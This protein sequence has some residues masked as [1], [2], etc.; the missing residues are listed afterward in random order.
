MLYVLSY[1]AGEKL[2]THNDQEI[3]KVGFTD[4]W[5]NRISQYRGCYHLPSIGYVNADKPLSVF[6]K[7]QGTMEQETL[8]HQC[9]KSHRAFD[10]HICE[11]YNLTD[12]LKQEVEYLFRTPIDWTSREYQ[13]DTKYNHNNV[14]VDWLKANLRKGQSIER[15]EFISY[16]DITTEEKQSLS[17]ALTKSGLKRRKELH[18][19]LVSLNI[20]LQSTPG[21]YGKTIIL[22]K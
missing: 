16:L 20:E 11:W 5:N 7:V 12:K 19:L 17:E 3:V 22:K 6:S 1:V 4:N 15:S 10:G 9:L 14:A 8:I 21:R 18:Q 13:N 2:I